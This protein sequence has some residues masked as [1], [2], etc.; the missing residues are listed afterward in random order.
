MLWILNLEKKLND[1]GL[2]LP[3]VSEP[4]GSYQSLNIRGNITYLAI[5][6]PILNGEFLYTGR[7]GETISTEEGFKAMELCALNV[8][9]QIHYK[10]GFERILGLN[11]IEAVYR[12]SQEWDEAPQVVDGA[13]EL[14]T[15]VLGEKG[16]H[17]R[18]IFG[19]DHLPMDFCVGLTTT[20]TFES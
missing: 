19:V 8:I 4:G 6:F 11:H 7:L 17:S 2:E 5:Q 14:F 13:S 15:K 3:S 1:L 18:S 10:V 9:S 20:F 12:S 16:R